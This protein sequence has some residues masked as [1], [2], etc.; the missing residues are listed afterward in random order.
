M[1]EVKVRK[2]HVEEINKKIKEAITVQ[3]TRAGMRAPDG[4][5]RSSKK[6]AAEP[7]EEKQDGPDKEQQ[8]RDL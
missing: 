3:K 2:M 8:L 4:K 7:K 5:G 1:D 6:G